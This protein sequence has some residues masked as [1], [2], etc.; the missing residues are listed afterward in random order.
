MPLRGEV[1]PARR[2]G[3]SERLHVVVLEEPAG[4]NGE[5]NGRPLC[6]QPD[7]GDP[8]HPEPESDPNEPHRVDEACPVCAERF[9][10]MGTGGVVL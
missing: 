7:E 2:P 8:W 10:E 1:I 3:G 4:P 5:W 9:R 6:E